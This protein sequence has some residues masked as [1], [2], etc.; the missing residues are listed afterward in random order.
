MHKDVTKVVRSCLACQKAKHPTEH[1]K[2]ELQPILPTRPLQL[3]S[4][5][6]Y[7]PL[8]KISGRSILHFLEMD[9]FTKYTRLCAVVNTA[10]VLLMKMKNFI[11]KVGSP[12]AVLNER[13]TKFISELWQHGTESCQP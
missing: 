13:G 6:L 9:I 7:G 4:L 8:N 10:S 5:A 11:E 12:K 2:G 1:L 3:V